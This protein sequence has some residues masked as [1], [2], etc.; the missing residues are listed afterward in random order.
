[1]SCKLQLTA[2]SPLPSRENSIYH[3]SFTKSCP[4]PYRR[5]PVLPTV[6]ILPD[7]SNFTVRKQKQKIKRKRKGARLTSSSLPLPLNL[8]SL[9]PPLSHDLQLL[10]FQLDE[11]IESTGKFRWKSQSLYNSSR[12]IKLKITKY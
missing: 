5:V 8:H 2:L 11:K 10:P 3:G 7:D 9:A 12:K 4:P 6:P 1:M